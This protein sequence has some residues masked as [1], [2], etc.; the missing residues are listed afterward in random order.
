MIAALAGLLFSL[1]LI[2]SGMTRPEKVRAF[3]DVTRDW[4]PS[5]ALVMLGAV[6]VYFA[7]WRISLG[8]TRPFAGERFP[9]PPQHHLDGRLL[10]GAAIFGAGW[11]LSGFCPGPA[12]VDAGTGAIQA[13]WFVPAMV[14]G[15]ALHRVLFR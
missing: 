14:A 13:L 9:K 8:L 12:L 5:L 1:G 2:V 4:D 3:L 11:G 6:A 15:M 7:A 10:A